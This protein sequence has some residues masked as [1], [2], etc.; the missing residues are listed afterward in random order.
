[1]QILCKTTVRKIT[2]WQRS[3][4]SGTAKRKISSS[5]KEC[6]HLCAASSPLQLF[7]THA[8]FNPAQVSKTADTLNLSTQSSFCWILANILNSSL[9]IPCYLK[10][11]QNANSNINFHEKLPGFEGAA[12]ANSHL[13]IFFHLC[14]GET[15][16]MAQPSSSLNAP[17]LSS[18]NDA[19]SVCR[20]C[21]PRARMT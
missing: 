8:D 21:S 16:P 6:I 14:T 20:V 1:M 10:N 15:Q 13:F 2:F 7:T 3:F 18:R 9:F 17:A 11:Q 19:A 12:L 5:T 4:L